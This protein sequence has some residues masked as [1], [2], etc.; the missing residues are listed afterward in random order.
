[1]G[2]SPREAALLAVRLLRLTGRTPVV[3]PLVRD[4][5]VSSLLPFVIQ[6]VLCDD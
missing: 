5:V 2:G 4:D 1:V 6:V 3:V